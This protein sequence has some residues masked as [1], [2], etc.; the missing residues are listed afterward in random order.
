MYDVRML[1][2]A[3]LYI[4]AMSQ[5]INPL[6]G[7]YV[8]EWDTVAQERIQRCMGY[9]VTVLDDVLKKGVGAKKQ[10][11]QITSAQKAQVQLSDYE[12]GV[13]DLSKR[14]NDTID[15]G[16][17]KGITGNKIAE[18]LV[19]KGFLSVREEVKTTKNTVKILNDKAIQLGISSRLRTKPSGEA[20]EQLM[21]SRQAQ[22]FILDHIDEIAKGNK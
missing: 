4:E 5:G 6:T 7:E 3:R 11:F 17:V 16:F 13:N 14:I 2:R 10:E 22:Q 8:P 9:V 21:Y 1:K 18:W 20:Y 12:I 15:T 19:N